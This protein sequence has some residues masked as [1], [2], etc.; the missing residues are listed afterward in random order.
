MNF[1][2]YFV[3]GVSD[4]SEYHYPE[5]SYQPPC[6]VDKPNLAYRF[7]GRK[8]WEG[9][10][11]TVDGVYKFFALNPAKYEGKAA[12]W[13]NIRS[14][15]IRLS[16]LTGIL[17]AGST[18]ALTAGTRLKEIATQIPHFNRAKHFTATATNHAITFVTNTRRSHQYVN[19]A[20]TAISRLRDQFKSIP[21]LGLA[22]G[23]TFAA[24]TLGL[25][26]LGIRRAGQ[27]Y[28]QVED[29][30]QNPIPFE[31]TD[32]CTQRQI[33]Q[34]GFMAI[35]M[36]KL[37][38]P[39]FLPAEIKHQWYEC[40]L[41]CFTQLPEQ[42]K[43]QTRQ[44]IESFFRDNPFLEEYLSNAKLTITPGIV[45]FV[46]IKNELQK[47]FE[48]FKSIIS[49]KKAGIMERAQAARTNNEMNRQAALKGDKTFKTQA[50]Q[51]VDEERRSRLAY[52]TTLYDAA[53]SECNRIESDAISNINAAYRK[54]LKQ[55]YQTRVQEITI[56]QHHYDQL[57]QQDVEK[58]SKKKTDLINKYEYEEKNLQNEKRSQEL[59]ILDIKN[60]IDQI[61]KGIQDRKRNKE[62]ITKQLESNKSAIQTNQNVIAQIQAL[63][64]QKENNN[65]QLSGSLQKL[66]ELKIEDSEARK[67]AESNIYKEFD[68]KQRE[69]RQQIETLAKSLQPVLSTTQ[70][71][72]LQEKLQ[73]LKTQQA[74][75]KQSL[76]RPKDEC[77][78]LNA[79]KDLTVKALTELKQK[80]TTNLQNRL[81]EHQSK[82]K[83]LR[84][85]KDQKIKELP[86][87]QTISTLEK[88]Q[89]DEINRAKRDCTLSK[90]NAADKFNRVTQVI[91]NGCAAEKRTIEQKYTAVVSQI[92]PPFDSHRSALNVWETAELKSIEGFEEQ[93]IQEFASALSNFAEAYTN[94][95]ILQDPKTK[96]KLP[97]PVQETNAQLNQQKPLP[98]FRPSEYNPKSS[99]PYAPTAPLY[100]PNGTV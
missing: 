33:G 51:A 27:A 99:D 83:T 95:Q 55:P 96:V 23:I 41:G 67:G 59:E 84:N 39:Y 69:T 90:G 75:A 36:R 88:Q 85:E 38:S 100:V 40:A 76:N 18:L 46:E 56:I 54:S 64:S 20:F 34:K 43:I 32:Y 86:I 5:F 62:T 29:W 52:E 19:S 44:T 7:E 10:T 50:L 66:N 73:S 53:I 14:R 47:R 92:E 24:A 72:K 13:T 58:Y 61:E 31:I 42:L 48:E 21:H 37:Q 45:V 28:E 2:S 25:T 57:L 98:I 4:N 70:V 93:K 11:C 63:D 97:Y 89:E 81:N 9:D 6:L 12:I 82:Q 94:P 78:V 65:Q 80:H 30:S 15:C 68:Q 16:I 87:Q 79:K 8:V 3:N 77:A 49:A 60:K 1:I 74:R 71:E 91:E 22:L 17:S 35:H 26:I